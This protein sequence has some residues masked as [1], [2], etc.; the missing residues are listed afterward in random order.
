MEKSSIFLSAVW[1]CGLEVRAEW[2]RRHWGEG[3][4][5]VLMFLGFFIE[6]LTLRAKFQGGFLYLA[7]HLT[8]FLIFDILK[9]NSSTTK[10]NLDFPLSQNFHFNVEQRL[11]GKWS[12]VTACKSAPA[13]VKM[14]LFNYENFLLPNNSN[15]SALFISCLTKIK[16]ESSKK[17]TRTPSNFNAIFFP[18]RFLILRSNL[19]ASKHQSK[20]NVFD[21][22]VFCR[23]VWNQINWNRVQRDILQFFLFEMFRDTQEVVLMT[24]CWL[25]KKF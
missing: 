16:L 2:R 22:S 23:L 24:N 18:F 25:L 21:D 11:M 12:K 7:P 14:F 8:E 20:G 17:P 4:G 10:P 13:S 19:K 3:E 6:K 1:V 15:S 9:P 5:R